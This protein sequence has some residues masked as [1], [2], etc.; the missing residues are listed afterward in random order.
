[1]VKGKGDIVGQRKRYK[2]KHRDKV[3]ASKRRYYAKLRLEVL[4][5]Y[6]NGSLKCAVCGDDHLEFLGID[7]IN[8]GGNKHR[9]EIKTLF[10]KWL[11]VNNYPA[12]FQVL[13]SNCNMKK[14][15]VAARLKGETGTK[16][17]RKYYRRASRLKADLL[18]HYMI[19]G[20]IRC[21]CPDCKVTDPDLLCIDHINNDGAE[22]R[23]QLGIAENAKGLKMYMWI[24]R[25]NY[26]PDF[27]ILC[28]NCNQS[29]GSKG[30]CPH[31]NNYSIFKF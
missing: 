22:H 28:H 11:K 14:V 6:S 7:H 19:D 18:N 27:R 26:P 9:I 24:K 10:Y 21:A 4:T 23:R 31:D 15:K 20:K 30:Y 16:E 3:R 8:G 1:M 2:Q 12:G 17:Q 5:H 25:N 13:C 29:L